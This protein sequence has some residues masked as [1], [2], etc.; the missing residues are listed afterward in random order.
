MR[1]L[2]IVIFILAVASIALA[3]TMYIHLDNGTTEEID[4]GSIESITFGTQDST[5][6]IF[7]QGGTFDMGDHY[8]EG[9]SDELPVHSV[10]LDDFYIGETEVTNQQVI[11]VFNWALGQGYIN[12]SSSTVTNNQGDSQ[13]LLDLDD[14]NCAISWN[15]SSLEFSGSSY[16]S[17]ADCPCIEIT[18]YGSVAF[19]NYK[20]LQEGLDT[21]YDLSDWSCGWDANGYRL[22]TEAE[23]EYAARGGINWTDDYRYSGCHNEVDLSDYAWYTTNAD[24]THPVGTRLPNQLDIYDMSGNVYE[25]CWDWYVDDYYSS[26]PTNNPTGPGSGSSRVRRG[27]DWFYYANYCRVAHRLGSY[28]GYSG[29]GAGFRLLRVNLD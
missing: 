11:D 24:E 18:W 3:G 23:W 7:V 8:D 6:L 28:P 4:I 22:P 13:E 1:K 16:A 10:T 21:C 17:T 2:F 14:G 29:I 9:E 27:G 12:C 20:S 26:S 15:G 5:D 19:C 25:W